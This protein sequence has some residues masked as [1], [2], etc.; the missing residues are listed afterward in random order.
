MSLRSEIDNM[1]LEELQREL[2]RIEGEK[3]KEREKDQG[4]EKSYIDEVL[5]NFDPMGPVSDVAQLF[6]QSPLLTL[7]GLGKLAKGGFDTALSAVHPGFLGD[8]ISQD[9]VEFTEAMREEAQRLTP[10]GF[11]KDP[12]RAL[13][14]L[15]M[16]GTPLKGIGMVGK[17]G[18]AARATGRAA[19]LLDPVVAAGTVIKGVGAPAIAKGGPAARKMLQAG[20]GLTSGQG[21]PAAEKL[22]DIGAESA[23]ARRRLSAAER[24]QDIPISQPLEGDWWRDLPPEGQAQLAKLAEQRAASQDVA[25][26]RGIREGDA[27]QVGMETLA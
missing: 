23:A 17:L 4:Q 15:A 27:A 14:T 7:R 10:E 11:K 18:K 3:E 25:A 9:Q 2:D 24:G 5:A 22:W 19:E 1:S 20:L 12:A 26:V 8:P 16:L 6:Q 21:L 13:T